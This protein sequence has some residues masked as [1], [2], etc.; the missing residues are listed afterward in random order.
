MT[1]KEYANDLYNKFYAIIFEKGEELSQEIVI[2]LLAKECA[3]QAVKEM[4]TLQLPEVWD[5]YFGKILE[6][7]DKM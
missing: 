1:A 5:N 2:S 3:K 7:L 4:F 6:E